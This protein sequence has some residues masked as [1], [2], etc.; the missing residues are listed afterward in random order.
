M[1]SGMC[2]Q[3][4]ASKADGF[5]GLRTNYVIISEKNCASTMDSQLK[6]RK[7]DVAS[8]TEGLPKAEVLNVL[9]IQG[10]AGDL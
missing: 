8:M 7:S 5:N 10:E 2:S 4:T 3:L 1:E 9:R 6:K